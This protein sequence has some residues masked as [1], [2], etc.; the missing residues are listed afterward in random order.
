MRWLNC[1]TKTKESKREIMTKFRVKR[2]NITCWVFFFFFFECLRSQPEKTFQVALVD[3]VLLVL[4]LTLS[5]FNT[6]SYIASINLFNTTAVCKICSKL[7]KKRPRRRDRFFKISSKFHFY[8]RTSKVW[9]GSL[10]YFSHGYQSLNALILLLSFQ[11][12]LPE[13]F[14]KKGVIKNFEDFTE[15]NLCWSLFLIKLQAFCEICGFF[16][17][18]LQTAASVFLTLKSLRYNNIR[19]S[20]HWY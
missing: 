20:L 17:E 7:T 15:K 11:R 9:S 18:Y 5:K 6:L 4:L 12:Q 14:C 19:F 1:W 10:F 2:F 3:F 16:E 13:G 8:A